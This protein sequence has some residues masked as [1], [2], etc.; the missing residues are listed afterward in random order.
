MKMH[1]NR[2]QKSVRDVFTYEISCKVDLDDVEYG[3]LEKYRRLNE[4]LDCGIS[5]SNPRITGPSS[6]KIS[7]LIRDYQT[8]SIEGALPEA[9]VEIPLRLAKNLIQLLDWLMARD[10]WGEGASAQEL[11]EFKIQREDE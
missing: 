6:I 4:L 7:F 2:G 5:G 10:K 3:L 11:I 8:W 1:I 9:F